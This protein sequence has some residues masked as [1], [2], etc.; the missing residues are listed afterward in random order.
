MKLRL[1]FQVDLEN[2]V[3]TSDASAIKVKQDLEELKLKTGA[4]RVADSTPDSR[5][6]LEE[7]ERTIT[8]IQVN[9]LMLSISNRID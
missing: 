3:K 5:H 1:L 4:S 7:L 9:D 8:A 2:V 6:K